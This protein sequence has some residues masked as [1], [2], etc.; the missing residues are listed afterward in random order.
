VIAETG[1]IIGYIIDKV[2]GSL[3]APPDLNVALCYSYFLH[4]PEGSLMPVLLVKFAAFS[5]AYGLR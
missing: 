5:A 2:R 3:S 1:A 4:Y